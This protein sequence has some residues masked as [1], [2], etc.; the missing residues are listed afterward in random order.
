MGVIAEKMSDESGLNWPVNVA[1]FHVYLAA[2]GEVKSVADKLYEE[3]QAAGIDVLY[4]DRDARPGDKFADAELMGI[5]YRL[6]VSE[7]SLK[8]GN[9]ELTIRVDGTV[10][11]VA[12][13]DILAELQKLVLS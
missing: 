4:D 12:M 1:P 11:Q 7:R 8:E 5:P 9:V 2:I 13:E 6:V 3:L 10:T